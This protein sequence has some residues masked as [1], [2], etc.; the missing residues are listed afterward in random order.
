[1]SEVHALHRVPFKF[2][3]ELNSFELKLIK[4]LVASDLIVL[5]ATS[6]LRG[7]VRQCHHLATRWPAVVLPTT[8]QPCCSR[9][10]LSHFSRKQLISNRNQLTPAVLRVTPPKPLKF[11][12]LPTNLLMRGES[13]ARFIRNSQ[14][15]CASIASFFAFLIWSLLAFTLDG[16]IFPQI[17]N[18]LQWRNLLIG[19]EKVTGAKMGRLLGEGF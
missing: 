7:A 19:S 8:W 6:R 16:G 17:F 1:L 18:S 9:G 12:I 15:L 14:H 13:F 4:L 10:S 3:V 11:R 5:I 2:A